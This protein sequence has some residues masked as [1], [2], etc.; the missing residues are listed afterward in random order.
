[1]C[2]EELKKLGQLIR[3]FRK[4]QNLSQ[5]Q[6]ASLAGVGINFVSQVENGKETAHIGKV[7]KLA[8]MVE[9]ELHVQRGKN[10]LV[11]K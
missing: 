3:K 5:Q 2:H 1:M 11:V 10:G 4:N 9:I 6:L 8:K 7:L